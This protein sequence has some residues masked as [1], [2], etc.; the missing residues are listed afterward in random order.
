VSL[1]PTLALDETGLD[2]TLTSKVS[3]G[4]LNFVPELTSW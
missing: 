2:L 1:A 4:W 3:A